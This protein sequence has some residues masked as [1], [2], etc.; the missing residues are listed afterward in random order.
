MALNSVTIVSLS[1][2]AWFC[3]KVDLLKSNTSSLRSLRILSTFSHF[4][5][6]YYAVPQISEIKLFQ[7]TVHSCFTMLTKVPLSL[8]KR[9]WFCPVVCSSSAIVKT[10]WIMHYLIPSF[11]SS[12]RTFHRVYKNDQIKFS[13]LCFDKNSS[14]CRTKLFWRYLHS[15]LHREFTKPKISNVD[16][17][18][19]PISGRQQARRLDVTWIRSGCCLHLSS[20]K[21]KKRKLVNKVGKQG[22]NCVSLKNKIQQEIRITKGTIGKESTTTWW[23]D[24]HEIKRKP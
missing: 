17:V 19:F 16:S 12:G 24:T 7:F 22:E 4:A 8:V 10:S 21:T 23:I 11:C 2:F 15:Q 13:S 3:N 14:S 5:W 18:T 20:I 9:C 1:C 6:L